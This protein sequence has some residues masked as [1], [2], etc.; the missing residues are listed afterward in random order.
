ME[1]KQKDHGEDGQ[2]RHL[3]QKAYV[4]LLVFNYGGK[5]V[6]LDFRMLQE[7]GVLGKSSGHLF[8]PLPTAKSLYFYIT[9][10]G[11]YYCTHAYAIRRDYFPRYLCS[12]SKKD[13]CMWST[14]GLPVV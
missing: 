3:R 14:G 4:F 10:I 5:N 8:T 11:H 12:A 7:T 13:V 1:K 2:I 6:R 9:Q